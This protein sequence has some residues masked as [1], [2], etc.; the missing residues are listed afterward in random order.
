VPP[1]KVRF[2]DFAFTAEGTILGQASSDG[3]P[4]FAV[5][6]RSGVAV[7]PDQ[8]RSRAGGRTGYEVF[9][10]AVQLA[11]GELTAPASHKA[12][13]CNLPYLGLPL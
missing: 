4:G 5:V 13:M 1:S 2:V 11:S 6:K 12:N 10:E 7:D 9:D 3:L 8:L